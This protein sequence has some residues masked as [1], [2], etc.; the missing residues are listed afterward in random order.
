MNQSL[1]AYSLSADKLVPNLTFSPATQKN[2]D[3]L[4]L[5]PKVKGAVNQF[6]H[7]QERRLLILKTDDVRDVT[8]YLEQY[9][10]QHLPVNSAENQF[11]YQIHQGKEHPFPRVDL[12]PVSQN[13]PAFVAPKNVASALFFD[14]NE[15]FGAVSTQGNQ[16]QLRAGLLHQLQ[17]GVL[18]LSLDALLQDFS[19]WAKLKQA[20]FTQKAQWYS[21]DPFKTLPCAIPVFP[22]NIKVILIGDRKSLALLSEEEENI[23][24]FADYAEFERELALHND[25]AVQQWA[26]FIQALV[27][28]KQLEIDSD[29]LNRL[30]QILVRETEDRFRISLSPLKLTNTLVQS[31]IFSHTH[32]LTGEALQAYFKQRIYQQNNLQEQTIEAIIQDQIY[33][34][35]EGSVV[36]QIN[37][38]SVIE[39]VGVPFSFGEPIR[40]SCLVQFGEG[41]IVDVERKNELAGNLHSKGLMIAQ[42][43]L[44]NI[45]N[46]P[47]QLPFAATVVFEQSYGEIDGDSASLACLL[48][49]VSALADEPIPQNIAV[50]GS[51]DQFGIVHTVGGVNDKVEGFFT[52]C[53]QRGLT[54]KQGVI[55]PKNTLNQLSLMPEVVQ[56]V[57]EKQFHL[58]I[59]ED[60]NQAS[61]IMFGQP[62]FSNQ[63]TAELSLVQRI[64]Q[65]LEHFAEPSA[66]PSFWARL[67][68]RNNDEE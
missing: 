61:E 68:H 42:A 41:E 45:L 18:I 67:F 20:L 60:V 33:V 27:A 43:C 50:T 57:K 6:L 7:N 49:L 48:S 55:I 53:K 52:L 29:G 36:G 28:E 66:K 46:L 11:T 38:L 39:Y 62:L 8:P 24:D 56:A 47:A 63:E 19:L 4:A 54:G 15:L 51:I 58:W 37:G 26:A 25:K 9:I 17:Q 1:I 3:F 16:I 64:N 12:V 32:K 21:A 22:L 30:Y 31:A 13:N 35:T 14:Q 5:Q 34:A 59:V 65:R 44:S 40:I 2:L 10:E 23:Y